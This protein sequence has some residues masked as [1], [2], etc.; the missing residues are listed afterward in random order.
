MFTYNA[1]LNSLYPCIA[2]DDFVPINDIMS[3]T[4]VG[5][6]RLSLALGTTAQV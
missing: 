5:F 6:L 4:N 2:V 3:G 1:I